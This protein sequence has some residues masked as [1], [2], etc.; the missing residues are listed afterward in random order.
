MYSGG[1]WWDDDR[2]RL[3]LWYKCGGTDDADAAVGDAPPQQGQ[4]PTTAGTCLAYSSDGIH[5]DK[6]LQDVRPGTNM[7]R[8]VAFDGNTVWHDRGE[9]NASRRYKMADVDDVNTGGPEWYSHYT[10]LSS[11]D[12]VHWHTEINRTA[13]ASRNPP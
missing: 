11:P 6:P 2:Q 13:G 5:F 10:L 9:K 4:G 7:V 12:G 8:E 3:A 1:A